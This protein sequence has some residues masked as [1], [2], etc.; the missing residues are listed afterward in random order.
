[1]NK[2]KDTTY[3]NTQAITKAEHKGKLIV[4]NANIKKKRNTLNQYLKLPSE[5]TGKKRA[6]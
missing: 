5:D 2:N 1:M 3:Q 6:N 4:V